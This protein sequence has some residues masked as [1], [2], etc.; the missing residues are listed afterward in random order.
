MACAVQA[1]K[2]M[3]T[4]A[5]IH[6]YSFSSLLNQAPMRPCGRIGF[7]LLL[8]V[9]QT[10]YENVNHREVDRQAAH[11]LDSGDE[12]IRTGRLIEA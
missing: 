8:L 2:P 1:V 4:I 3:A 10:R 5:T 9:N 7:L 11:V 12:R 6:F